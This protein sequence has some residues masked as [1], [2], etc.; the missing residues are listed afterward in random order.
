MFQAGGNTE[1]IATHLQE[2]HYRLAIAYDL[3]KSYASMSAQSV[4]EHHSGCKAKCAKEH[5]EQEGNEK[6][7]RSHKKTSKAWEQEKAS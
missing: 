6:V 4:L 7:K 2:V 5:A 1:M 3:C